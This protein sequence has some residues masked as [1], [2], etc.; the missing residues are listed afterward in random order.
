[1]GKHD[2]NDSKDL[3]TKRPNSYTWAKTVSLGLGLLKRMTQNAL[4]GKLLKM[5]NGSQSIKQHIGGSEMNASSL[6]MDMLYSAKIAEFNVN[7]ILLS[8]VDLAT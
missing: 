5:L 4:A 6:L 8:Y 2:H 3:L 1:M 7:L